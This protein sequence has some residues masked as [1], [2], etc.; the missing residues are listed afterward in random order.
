MRISR[1]VVTAAAFVVLF[2]VTADAA[3]RRSVSLFDYFMRFFGISTNNDYPVPP[4]PRTRGDI[5]SPAQPRTTSPND[6]PVPP[7]P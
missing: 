4:Y 7:I 2:A 5:P 6:Y 1:R 3:P